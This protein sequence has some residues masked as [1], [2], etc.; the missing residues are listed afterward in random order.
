MEISAADGSV[1]AELAERRKVAIGERQEEFTLPG[2]Y[3]SRLGIRVRNIART[4]LE[5][6]DRDARREAAKANQP[7]M[8]GIWAQCDILVRACVE[9][10]VRDTP[11]GKWRVL[12]GEHPVRFDDRLAQGL[13]FSWTSPRDAVRV[14]FGEDLNLETFVAI[15]EAWQR[16]LDAYVDAQLR[17]AAQGNS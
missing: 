16:N 7:E 14:V 9:L 5:E 12:G 1:L 4:E 3:K 13:Q 2:P 11:D 8:G 10:L 15:Y 17:E 6:I